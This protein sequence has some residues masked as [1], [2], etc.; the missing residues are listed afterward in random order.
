MPRL[1]IELQHGDEIG[2]PRHK[3]RRQ[4]W[5]E[6]E[7]DDADSLHRAWP[8]VN[9]ARV[10]LGL[11]AAPTVPCVAFWFWIGF[12]HDFAEIRNLI[13]SS[14][15][16]TG[17]AMCYFIGVGSAFMLWLGRTYGVVA[18]F[19][20]LA[21]G[22]SLTFSM[23]PLNVVIDLISGPRPDNTG[24]LLAMLSAVTLGLVLVPFGIFGGWMLWRIAIRPASVP[25]KEMAEIF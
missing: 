2:T 1:P 24:S 22:A 23:P 3:S 21:L 17:L 10:V 7:D 13:A 8:A 20:C 14:I 16:S 5:R 6:R 19:N 15:T 11:G 12:S 25:L 4:Q 9:K 18:R